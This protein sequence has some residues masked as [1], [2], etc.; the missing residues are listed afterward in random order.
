[1]S[2][3]VSFKRLSIMRV[4]IVSKVRNCAKKMAYKVKQAFKVRLLKLCDMKNSKAV[5]CAEDVAEQVELIYFLED[6][7]V[8]RRFHL[9]T[10]SSRGGRAAHRISRERAH[11][12]VSPRL[13][14]RGL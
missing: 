14:S 9:L 13:L 4:S 11:P 6:D 5:D 3:Y 7:F 2:R 1:M 12:S 8:V 10:V